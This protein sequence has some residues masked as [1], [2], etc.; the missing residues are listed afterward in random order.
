[1]RNARAPALPT[2]DVGALFY[3]WRNM[4]E[5]SNEAPPLCPI[6]E[7]EPWAAYFSGGTNFERAFE[8]CEHE[9]A[10]LEAEES[11][12]K[13]RLAVEDWDL[14]ESAPGYYLEAYCGA[15]TT[16]TGSKNVC[17]GLQPYLSPVERRA[18]E[19]EAHG[20]YRRSHSVL[21]A[22]FRAERF[23]RRQGVFLFGWSRT[24][25]VPTLTVTAIAS[26]VAEMEPDWVAAV[27]EARRFADDARLIAAW[28][29]IPLHAAM[30]C[31]RVV[32]SVD[33]RPAE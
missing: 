6:C 32:G 18:R 16:R 21:R 23:H 17:M 26:V 22:L 4:N 28:C 25:E 31:L 1:M 33:G 29:E 9:R 12:G 7:R 13:R 3:A 11:A 14:G 8:P 19:V 10:A 30:G 24:R 20:Y 2:G 15:W 5:R 27:A